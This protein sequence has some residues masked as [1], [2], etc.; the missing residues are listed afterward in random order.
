[1]ENN[2]P[3]KKT[4]ATSVVLWIAVAVLAALNFVALR[5]AVHSKEQLAALKQSFEARLARLDERAHA[6]DTEAEARA[7]ALRAELE[8]ARRLAAASAGQAK[9]R[10]EQLVNRLAAEYQKQQEQIASEIGQVR[11]SAGLA[12]EKVT[13]V[14]GD[15]GAVR[16]EVAETRSAVE[17]TRSELEATRA[18]LRSVKGDL[19]IQSGLIATNAR[20]LAALKELGERHYIE[21][22]IGKK[23]QP[24]KLGNV[25]VILRKTKPKDLKFTVDILAD[26]KRIE[27]RDRTV[28]EPVQFYVSGYRQPYE[29]VVNEVRKD[30][31][32]GYLAIPKVLR[33]E[34]R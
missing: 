8:E 19:G 2:Q 22:D 10:A 15:V 5:E 14:M 34:N 12:N 30:A 4:D 18:E 26:D 25:S 24:V 20:E 3:T 11:Q 27:K 21:F 13:A 7:A 33:A 9:V 17:R 6:I 31:I 29:L 32:I 1:M 16:G 23:G 28:N